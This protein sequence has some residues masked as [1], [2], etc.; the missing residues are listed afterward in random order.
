MKIENPN[1]WG[2]YS[3]PQDDEPAKL[4]L[5]AALRYRFLSRTLFRDQVLV[6]GTGP[7][8]SPVRS[9]KNVKA[10]SRLENS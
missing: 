10:R 4:K 9:P 6:Y 1:S 3:N 8:P 5:G 7:G 2:T